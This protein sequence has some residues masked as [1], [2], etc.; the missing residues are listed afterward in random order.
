VVTEGETLATIARRWSTT[1][2]TLMMVNNLVRTDVPVGTRVKLPP[3]P[4]GR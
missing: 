3:P 1:V 4:S 2:T